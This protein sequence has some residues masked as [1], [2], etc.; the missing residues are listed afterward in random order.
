M[1]EHAEQA[2]LFEWAAWNETRAPELA[3]LFAIPN[4]GARHKAT[5]AKMKAEGQRAGVPDCFLP[6]ARR[7]YHGLWIEMKFGSNQPTPVQR[8]W[9]RRLTKQGY[10][11]ATCRSW[12]MAARTIV[13]YLGYKQEDFGL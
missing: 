10:I 12:E 2:A 6:V 3:L 11:V 1:S 9:D 7:D 13:W 5:A 4:G 8:D